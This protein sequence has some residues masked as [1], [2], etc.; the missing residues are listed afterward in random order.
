MELLA[1]HV[2]RLKTQKEGLQESGRLFF[3]FG[4]TFS[5][6]LHQAFAREDLEI[7]GLAGAQ[8]IRMSWS[9]S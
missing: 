9:C 6:F 7:L 3:A 1:E 2:S 4:H 8:G 5:E